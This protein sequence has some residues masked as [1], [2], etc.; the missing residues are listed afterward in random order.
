MDRRGDGR[1]CSP[2]SR[3]NSS[4]TTQASLRRRESSETSNAISKKA[5]GRTSSSSADCGIGCTSSTTHAS[6]KLSKGA[7]STNSYTSY[8]V[9]TDTPF[10]GFTLDWEPLFKQDVMVL[11][12]VGNRWH[13][14]GVKIKPKWYSNGW[15]G[16]LVVSAGCHAR[17][18]ADNMERGWSDMA[19]ELNMPFE[20]RKCEA[21]GQ[22][23]KIDPSLKIDDASWKSNPPTV[24][25][26]HGET[27]DR[28]DGARRGKN[29]EPL[30]GGS[31]AR[32][33]WWCSPV[34]Y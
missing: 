5:T 14:A 10:T 8:S 26:S 11:A 16:A 24:L 2:W 3:K 18:E 23:G 7:E 22:F 30:V 27:Q 13:R 15:S 25:S 6:K 34:P 28:G 32:D 12:N 29:G 33:A 21:G 31:T 20:I 9:F 4:I 17:P 1:F 19:V